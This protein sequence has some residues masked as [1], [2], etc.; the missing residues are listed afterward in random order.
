[1]L[2]TGADGGGRR[3]EADEILAGMYAVKFGLTIR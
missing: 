1:V 3:F 2:G